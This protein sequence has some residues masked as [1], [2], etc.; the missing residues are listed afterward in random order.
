MYVTELELLAGN[1]VRQFNVTINGVIWT[2][3][4]YKPVYL[5]TDA[6]YNGDRP[7][8]GIPRYNFSLNAAGSSTLP[9]ILNAAEAFSVISTADLATDAQDGKYF[10]LC[11]MI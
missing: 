7:Y 5:S 10:S 4:P 9:P 3:A 11:V 6:M 2:K 8:R 1:A